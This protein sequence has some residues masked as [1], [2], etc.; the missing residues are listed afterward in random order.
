[1]VKQRGG[2]AMSIFAGLVMFI[3]ALVFL[4][5]VFTDFLDYKIFVQYYLLFSGVVYM[6]SFIENRK[7]YFRPGWI[8]TQGF[9]QIFLGILFLF[10]QNDMYDETAMRIIYSL[11][12]LMTGASQ[13]SS[14]IQ[15]K[16]LEI[17]RWWL[18]SAEG[19]INVFWCF[20]LIVNPFEGLS[21]LYFL[22]GMFFAS[23]SI[24]TI[25]E[26]FLYRR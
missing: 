4:F 2:S 8:L 21:V 14:G 12:A 24:G 13:I 26:F 3:P 7:G 19:L 17:R 5:Q 9:L 16:A 23:V 15:L 1:M 20:F 25:L 18:V 6:I 22:T 11:W 10:F